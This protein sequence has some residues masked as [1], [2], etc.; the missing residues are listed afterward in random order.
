MFPLPGPVY[1]PK[2]PEGGSDPK[3]K[4]SVM[5]RKYI[6]CR[7]FPESKC[8]ISLSA[9]SEGELVEAAVQHGVKVHGFRDTPE[10]REQLRGAVKSGCCC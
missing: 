1:L 9:D 10:T 7:E 8:T 5:D 4:E 3:R 2:R 6:D